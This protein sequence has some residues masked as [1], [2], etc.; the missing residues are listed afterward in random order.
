[1]SSSRVFYNLLYHIDGFDGNLESKPS[2]LQFTTC[3]S[4]SSLD[5]IHAAAPTP[6]V[7]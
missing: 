5:A 6:T 4:L 7:I 2:L 3:Q 1:M